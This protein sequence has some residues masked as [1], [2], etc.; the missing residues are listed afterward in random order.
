MQ[1][2]IKTVY[3]R[4]QYLVRNPTFSKDCIMGEYKVGR[5]AWQGVGTFP[6]TSIVAVKVVGAQSLL[7]KWNCL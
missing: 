7:W 3:A 6:W 4:S 2:K 1:L 5:Y